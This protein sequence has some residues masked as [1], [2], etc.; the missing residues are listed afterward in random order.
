MLRNLFFLAIA[1]PVLFATEPL[2]PSTVVNCCTPQGITVFPF[3]GLAFTIPLPFGPM[4]VV[5]SE[6][7]D[8]IFAVKRR[9][10]SPH[11]GST[12]VKIEFHPIRVGTLWES[13]DEIS[14]FAVSTGEDKLIVAEP[15]DRATK[16]CSL[17]EISL[18]SGKMR[19]VLESS[20][21][22]YGAPW[23]EISLSPAGEH[24]LANVGRDLELIDLARGTLKPLGTQFSKGIWDSGAAWSPD[25][26]QIAVMESARRGKVFLLDANDLSEKRVLH[27]GYHRMTPVWSPDSRYLVRSRLQLRCG[28]GIDIDPPFTLEVVDVETG[29]Q[30]LIRSSTCKME[31][32]GTGW[33][34]SD[35]IN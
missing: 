31:G 6:K 12:V 18:P 26:K 8:A 35:L 22:R 2:R 14:G 28:I 34:R 24:A 20:D 4:D 23:N 9:G 11:N 33:L 30:A 32:L 25:G 21:C 7:G 29:K 1:W 17:I 15:Q 13:S 3:N 10:A 16:T 27:S 5:F 19:R